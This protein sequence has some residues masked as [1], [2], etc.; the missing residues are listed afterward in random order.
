MLY[1][2]YHYEVSTPIFDSTIA[3]LYNYSVI[4]AANTNENI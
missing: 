1:S 4:I 3:A 2:T